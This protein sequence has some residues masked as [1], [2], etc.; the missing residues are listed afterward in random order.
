MEQPSATPTPPDKPPI[1][2]QRQMEIY[3]AGLR[4]RKPAQPA[5]ADELERKAQAGRTP[6]ASGYLAGGAG[7]EDTMRANRDAFGRWRLVPRLLRNV[8]RRELGVDVLGQR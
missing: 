7:S 5:P 4:G 2:R 6:E 1:G 3:L 8:R